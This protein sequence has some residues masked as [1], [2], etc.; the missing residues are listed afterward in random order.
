MIGRGFGWTR[1]LILAALIV[2]GGAHSAPAQT[3][4]GVQKTGSGT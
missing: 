2:V 1:K 3:D 4:V